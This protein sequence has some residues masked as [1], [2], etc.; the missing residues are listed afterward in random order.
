[1]T[2]EYRRWVIYELGDDLRVG[3][4]VGQSYMNN[5]RPKESCPE[6]F[7]ETDEEKVWKLIREKEGM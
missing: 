3:L 7:Y 5:V 2:P 1:M 6:I 4:R